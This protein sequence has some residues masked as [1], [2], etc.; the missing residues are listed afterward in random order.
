MHVDDWPRW[1]RTLIEGPYIHHCAMGYGRH[2]D[3]LL[4]ACKFVPGLQP[5][6][7]GRADT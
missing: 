6:M 2:A 3:A 7:L 4:Q 5:V 1:E